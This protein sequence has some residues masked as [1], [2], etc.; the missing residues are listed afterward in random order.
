YQRLALQHGAP[1]EIVAA[2][3]NTFSPEAVERA[4][5][6]GMTA[7][8]AETARHNRATEAI[9]RERLAAEQSGEG[10]TGR[11]SHLTPNRK[12]EIEAS[13]ARAYR[14]LEDRIRSDYTDAEGRI[15]PEKKREIALMKI[16]IENDKRVQL[17]MPTL[18]DA[19]I[20]A[21][22]EGRHGDLQRV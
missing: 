6:L 11:G 20:K 3:G 1:A 9:Q 14:E 19:E 13:A 12:S 16:Q 17:G 18:F 8:E 5:Q 10:G 7:A 4:K 22:L 2:F 15:Y 21:A